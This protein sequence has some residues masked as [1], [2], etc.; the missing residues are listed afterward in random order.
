MCVNQTIKLG[1]FMAVHLISL[2]FFVF[3]YSATL[4]SEVCRYP[5]KKHYKLWWNANGIAQF[6]RRWNTPVHNFFYKHIHSPLRR[7]VN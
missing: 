3:E 4:W 5:D 2:G 1:A 6:W 7:A